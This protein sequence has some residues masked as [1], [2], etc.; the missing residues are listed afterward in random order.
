M[1]ANDADAKRPGDK[2]QTDATMAG[3]AAKEQFAGKQR[4]ASMLEHDGTTCT[5]FAAD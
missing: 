2:R 3:E 5:A 4:F 1:I